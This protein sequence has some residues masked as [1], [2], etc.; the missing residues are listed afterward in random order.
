[1]LP[2]KPKKIP[3]ILEAHG[4]KRFDDYYWLRD[5]TR[6]NK[7]I[8]SYLEEENTYAETWFSEG[9]DYRKQVFEELR[10]KNI[11]VN[12]HYIPVHL[13][14]YYQTMG[15]KSGDFP[16]AEQYSKEAISIPIFHGLKKDQQDEVIQA[17]TEGLA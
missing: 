1:M 5:D 3:K 11:G 15:F 10:S 14:P 12:L 2:P 17:I 6:Q 13:H 4:D 8:I 7:E 16:E 9:K